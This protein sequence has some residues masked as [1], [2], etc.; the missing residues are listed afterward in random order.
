MYILSYALDCFI[1]LPIVS[2]GHTGLESIVCEIKAVL[3]AMTRRIGY[4]E[5]SKAVKM[6]TVRKCHDC[7]VYYR[8]NS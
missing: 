4:N 5:I 1:F 3:Q 8:R 2:V 7:V 6:E